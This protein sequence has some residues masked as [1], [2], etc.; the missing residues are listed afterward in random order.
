MA[1]MNSEYGSEFHLLRYMG[2]HRNRLNASVAAATAATAVEWLDVPPDPGKPWGDGEWKGL[3][4]IRSDEAV[5]SAWRKVWPA[6]GNPP[7]WDAVGKVRI[8]DR[9]EWLLVEAKANEQELA[10]SCSAS[11]RGGLNL[12]TETLARTKQALGVAED[13]NW[14][15]GYYQYANRLAVLNF[16]RDQQIPAHLLFI[17][18]TGDKGDARRNCPVDE[19]AWDEALRKQS[20]HLGLPPDHPLQDRVHRVFLQ[21]DTVLASPAVSQA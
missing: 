19:N 12:I 3:N 20:N 18:F 14:L 4:F 21:V 9:W 2:R 17:Y 11:E 5:Q 10:S 13:K 15:N 6:R 16:L 8:A 1:A 7:N